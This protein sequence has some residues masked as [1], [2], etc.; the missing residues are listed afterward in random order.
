MK[1]N[2][3]KSIIYL[4]ILSATAINAQREFVKECLD[5]K[6][7]TVI[8]EVNSEGKINHV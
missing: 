5:V 8:C 2:I 3:L 6:D 7:L 1:L 4:L